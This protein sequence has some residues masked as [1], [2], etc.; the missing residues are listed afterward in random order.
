V[1]IGFT[2]EDKVGKLDLLG[3]SPEA[4]HC[5]QH[6]VLLTT[7]P[8]A[9]LREAPFRRVGNRKRCRGLHPTVIGLTEIL[10]VQAPINHHPTLAIA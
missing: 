3:K 10:G 9:C 4:L 1:E 7:V 2:L 6:E 8:D 5:G